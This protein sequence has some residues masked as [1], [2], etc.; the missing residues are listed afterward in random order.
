M[1]KGVQIE[2]SARLSIVCLSLLSKHGSTHR[3]Q[4]L[5]KEIS[6]EWIVCFSQQPLSKDLAQDMQQLLAL[7]LLLSICVLLLSR[8]RLATKAT[9]KIHC[10]RLEAFSRYDC[11]HPPSRTMVPSAVQLIAIGLPSPCV[12]IRCSLSPLRASTSSSVMTRRT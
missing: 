10:H 4:P 3:T 7:G 11:L 2:A 12:A 5:H 8:P 9:S 1:H 6:K